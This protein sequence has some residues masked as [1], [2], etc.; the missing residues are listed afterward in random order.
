MYITIIN[1]ENMLMSTAAT[2]KSQDINQG[3]SDS[4]AFAFT[5]LLMSDLQFAIIL[6]GLKKIP[7]KQVGLS[8]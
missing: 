1:S 8:L 2:W 5:T 7:L 6:A 4:R 3:L